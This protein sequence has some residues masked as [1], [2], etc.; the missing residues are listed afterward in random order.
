MAAI[1]RR[2][3]RGV[4]G[5]LWGGAATGGVIADP[6]NAGQFGVNTLHGFRSIRAG[7]YL[8]TDSTGA[9][10]PVP[11]KYWRVLRRRRVI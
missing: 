11:H 1:G 3:V 6:V 4:T 8:V 9:T 7:D 2:L 5:G 10:H